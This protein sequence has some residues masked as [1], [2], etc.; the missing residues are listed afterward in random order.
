MQKLPL[1]ISDFKEIR[2]NDYYFIDKSLFIKE[3]INE[4]AQVILLPR[5]RRFGK[6]LNISMLRYYFSISEA[7][8]SLYQNLKIAA[9]NEKY[10]QEFAKY[11]L[12]YLT[13]K[14]LKDLTWEDSLKNIEDIIAAE[15][16]R[17]DYLLKE[18]ILTEAE[19]KVYREII[20]LEAEKVHYQKALL[21][22]T[23]YLERYHD[24]KVIVLID[25]YDQPIQSGYLNDYYPEV[26][27]FMRLFLENGLKDN[28]SL[29]KSV[30]T[31]ILRVA[32]E[33]IFSG[34]NNLVV[35]DIFTEKYNQFFGL[36]PQEV[37]AVFKNYDL[38]YRLVEIKNWYNGYNYGGQT[39]YNPWS[40]I[41]CLYY[42]GEIKPYW[43]NSSGNE[44]IRELLLKGNEDLKS[45]LELLIQNQSIEKKIDENIVFAEI[46]SKSS[47]IWSFL[48]FSGYLSI[49]SSRRE[50]GR[51]FA[52]LEIPN[53]EIKYIY[54]E[55]FLDW[56]EE[57]I[58][59]QKLSLM[60]NA[61]T[62]GDVESF[63]QIFREFTINSL[64]Y[65][66]TSGSEAEK[67]YHAFV[68][69]LLLNLRDNY[70]V[71]SNRESGYGRYDIMII[72][73][74]KNKLGIIIEFKKIS[75]F[76]SESKKEALDSA[77]QQIEEKNY[78]A[79]LNSLGINDILKLAVVFSG[80]EVEVKSGDSDE[81]VEHKHF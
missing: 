19:E 2:K 30:L 13:F 27:N 72:P 37:E 36:L 46:E 45:S 65:F 62:E 29:H 61:L 11:P 28:A 15:Y 53:Q 14:G 64:S 12:I 24:Q 60:L 22:L 25:E 50:R 67:V 16:Q 10:L 6:T 33:S 21:R 35:N 38:E 1:G 42:Q 26:V 7:D 18:G 4:D 59:S 44:L 47:S 69:G 51:L 54:E 17:H 58:G 80:K 55:I 79:E 74:D 81:K 68:L 52:E 39:I 40:I 56:L 48:L 49:V 75:Q 73:D 31:G 66:D 70:Q 23:E 76:S 43:V 63:A 3:I 77:L 8:W 78:Q 32:K 71:K 9:E 41:N 34:L 57:N 5:P 20:N